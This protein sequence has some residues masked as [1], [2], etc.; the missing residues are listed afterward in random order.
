M[1]AAV[2]VAEEEVMGMKFEVCEVKKALEEGPSV[3]IVSNMN[4][5]LVVKWDLD[6]KI[7]RQFE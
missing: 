3:I 2:A 6:S 7:V 1:I 5:N 4:H